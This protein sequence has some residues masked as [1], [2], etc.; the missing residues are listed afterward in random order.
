[1]PARHGR[2]ILIGLAALGML[3][4]AAVTAFFLVVPSAVERELIERA[5][6]HGIEIRPHK[7]RLLPSLVIIEKA[8]LSLVGAPG[9]KAYAETIRVTLN[10]FEPRAVELD[11]VYC[12]LAGSIGSLALQFAEWTARYPETYGLPA[13]ATNVVI[14][15]SSEENQRPWLQVE[16]GAVARAATGGSFRAERAS[17]SGVDVGS[18]GAGWTTNEGSISIG[19]GETDL[20]RAPIRANFRQLSARPVVELVLEPTLIDKLA[21]PF[22]VQI[23]LRNVTASGRVQLQLENAAA[24]HEI[25]GDVTMKLVGFVPPHPPELDG[26]IFGD[27]TTFDSRLKIDKDRRLVTLSDSRVTAGAFTLAGGGSIVRQERH[28][29]IKLSLSGKLPCPAL[30]GA[31][32]ESRLGRVLGQLVGAAARKAM[33]GSVKVTVDIDGDTRNLPAARVER[34]IGIGCGLK[35][36]EL[37]GLGELGK[38][39]AQL[40]P[41]PSKLPELPDVKLEL[42]SFSSEPAAPAPLAEGAQEN[43]TR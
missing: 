30:A 17:V 6:R 22:A 21:A 36:L 9:L 14:A 20:G 33:Q 4:A 42:P 11:G 7:I 10:K 35:P 5:R 26:F 8:E 16:K 32:A 38:L 1:M 40:P 15:W 24:E 34:R 31:A 13:S 19:F 3:V 43:G 18:V 37:P 27:T 23:P 25:D 28:A 39:S 12:K 41:L 2:K 29:T